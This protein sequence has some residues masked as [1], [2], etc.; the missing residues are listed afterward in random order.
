MQN[1]SVFQR[2]GT[3]WV[4]GPEAKG[5]FPGQHGGALAG[6]LAATLDWEAAQMNA[7]IALQ[8]SILLLRP[9]PV[10]PCTVSTKVLR[11][12]GRVTVLAAS[13]EAGGKQCALA[14][15][16]YVRPQEVG[17]WPLP[18]AEQL[19]PLP[20]ELVPRPSAYGLE[21]WFRDTVEVRHSGEIYWLR[22][23]KA[24]VPDMTSMARVCAHADWASGL[25][26]VDTLEEPKVAGFPNV[27][28]SVH[29]ARE[30]RGEWIGLKPRS[31]WYAHGVGTTDTELYDVFGP[32]GRACHSLVLIPRAT[33][34]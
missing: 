16:I 29:L 18:S 19:A 1:S 32:L 9:A 14:Q 22:A 3:R 21:P 12:G 34:P 25:S 20:S 5:P 11:T 30:A 23:L 4:P 10:E 26:R 24:V 7:G 13:L 2:D 33:S 28:L 8:C 15:S 31:R 27:D 17:H 6:L